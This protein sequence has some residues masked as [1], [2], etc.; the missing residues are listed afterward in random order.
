MKTILSPIFYIIALV[1]LSVLCVIS[2]KKEEKIEPAEFTVAT[3]DVGELN[4][5]FGVASGILRMT[6]GKINNYGHCWSEYQNPTYEN[7]SKTEFGE[8]ADTK[9]FF[10]EMTNLKSGT[11]YFV[12][13]FAVSNNEV[14]YGNEMPFLTPSI[15]VNGT[16]ILDVKTNSV[17][18]SSS[19]D[20][21]EGAV[22]NYGFCWATHDNP[23][24]FDYKSELTILPS[25]GVY[26][27][28]I[29]NL[30]SE[31]TYYIRAYGRSEQIAYG[32]V[33][34]VYLE[35]IKLDNESI[36]Q[37]SDTEV[38]IKSSVDFNDV[39]II[40]HGHCWSLNSNPTIA[41]GHTELGPF[42]GNTYFLSNIK[43]LNENMRY[44]IRSYVTTI[45][46]T[47]YSDEI[48]YK[49]AFPLFIAQFPGDYRTEALT[50]TINDKIYL[51]FGFNIYDVGQKDI[52]LYNDNDNS[53]EKKADFPIGL[54][55]FGD[56]AM[57]SNGYGFRLMTS[58][59]IRVN[60][61]NPVTDSW[62][63]YQDFE[64]GFPAL[65][66][67]SA[68]LNNKLY[69]SMAERDGDKVR[70]FEFNDAN[71]TWTEKS[72][73]TYLSSD[74]ELAFEFGAKGYWISISNS[75]YM[76]EYNSLTNQWTEKSAPPDI[77]QVKPLFFTYN[78]K[79]Y[80]QY[81]TIVYQYDPTIDD[82]TQ[83]TDF[84]QELEKAVMILVNDNIYIGLG[85][86]YN[87]WYH[88]ENFYHYYPVISK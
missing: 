40:E 12:R 8:S 54:Y 71:E 46:T 43:D 26:Y 17:F 86:Y 56:Y 61:Y 88:N 10:S 34:S 19:I 3:G 4:G 63:S 27:E 44:N 36:D 58:D 31:K 22:V 72:S 11:M 69:I 25:S 15:K 49:L 55:N 18:L 87:A 30:Q 81:E 65:N 50:F 57:S 38:Q 70:L 77:G 59:Y 82:W 1:S 13:T 85:S 67:N 37:I 5:N 45:D 78:D 62:E 76:W 74:E 39:E 20:V 80:M 79:G 33:I 21:L 84:S 64:T 24:V 66:L 47:I 60:N 2:C 23:T 73:R 52:Y 35:R 9:E 14:I 6:S 42:T 28:E 7:D 51:G 53:W 32:P 68:Y 75:N 41:D 48:S 83:T 16:F 29:N